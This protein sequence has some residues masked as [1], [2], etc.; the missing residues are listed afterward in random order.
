MGVA[1]IP[2][3]A[4]EAKFTIA[5]IPGLTAD[6]FY[7]TMRKRARRLLTRWVWSWCSRARRISIR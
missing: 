2:A 5:L 1:A 6:G 3:Y 4:Q 7:I